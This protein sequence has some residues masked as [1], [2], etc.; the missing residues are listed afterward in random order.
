[1]LVLAV[2]FAPAFAGGK[3]EP[4]AHVRDLGRPAPVLVGGAFAPTEAVDDFLDL[5]EL[6]LRVLGVVRAGKLTL[7]ARA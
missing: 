3:Q 6:R 5:Q 4:V 1:M 2:V 7:C